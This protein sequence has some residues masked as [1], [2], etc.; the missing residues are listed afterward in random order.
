M[1][2]L[3]FVG[4]PLLELYMVIQVGQVIGA[5]WT[6]LLLVLDSVVG[7]I[8]VGR[9]GARAW[10]A[11]RDTLARGGV[12]AKELAAQM[13]TVRGSRRLRRRPA[14]PLAR[15]LH[16]W[17]RMGSVRS[18]WACGGSQGCQEHP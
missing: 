4:M 9:E 6:I 7:A 13:G 17:H 3:L 15:V 10:R 5:G 1:L 18:T 16:P 8:V 11:L 2:L 14:C 12:P